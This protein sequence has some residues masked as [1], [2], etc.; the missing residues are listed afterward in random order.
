MLS[1]KKNLMSLKSKMDSNVK[2]SEIGGHYHILKMAS[3]IV[4][5][6]KRANGIT[7]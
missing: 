4:E 1:L 6:E 2:N 3:R 5:T 7:N